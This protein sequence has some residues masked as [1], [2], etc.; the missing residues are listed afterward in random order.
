MREVTKI[1]VYW[2]ESDPGNAGYAYELS[3]DDGS[4]QS[5]PLRYAT[6][7][8]YAI[9]EAIGESGLEVSYFDFAREPNIDGGFATWSKD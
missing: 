3:D 9:G 8:D 7:L 2:D 4:I 1:K 5:G 6:S